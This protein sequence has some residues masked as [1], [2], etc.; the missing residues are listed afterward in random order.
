MIYGTNLLTRCP[1]PVPVF[2]C[3]FVLENLF[4]EV[5]RIA[6]KIYENYFQYEKKMEPEGGLQGGP[7]APKRQP[8]AAQGLA[9]P[10]S[11][12]DRSSTSSSRPFSY[13]LSS[14]QKP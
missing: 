13:K 7:T 4:W 8:G 3:L 10:G 5:S 1:V 12:L 14:M 9:A 2:C 6:L 11:H